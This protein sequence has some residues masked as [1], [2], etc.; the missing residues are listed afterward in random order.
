MS[1]RVLRRRLFARSSDRLGRFPRRCLIPQGSQRVA[2]GGVPADYLCDR[3]AVGRT[4]SHCVPVV[5]ATLDQ[6]LPSAIP[7]GSHSETA[8]NPT[9]R[10][11]LSDR[12]SVL[13][14]RFTG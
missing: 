4:M 6:R 7:S 1:V 14:A 5:F 9:A 10:E 12:L 2:G 11:P 13:A 3:V 8:Q